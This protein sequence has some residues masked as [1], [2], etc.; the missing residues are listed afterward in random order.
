MESL[1][2]Q[3]LIAMPNLK[4]PYF[5]R[6]V[7]YVCEHNEE[8]AMGLVINIPVDLSLEALLSQID[9]EDAPETIHSLAG[10]PVFQGGPVAQERGFVLHSPKPGY[11]S[12]LSLSDELMV[13]TSTDVLA[14][15]GTHNEPEHYLVTLGYAGWSAGQLEEELASNSW[16]NLPADPA[17]IFDVPSKERWET[18][19]KKIG[20]DIW[21]ISDQVGHA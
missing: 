14:A 20:I 16:L 9:L 4:D 11:S 21:Q 12:S 7:I 19:A 1:Q 2:N 17:I 15:L 6:A 3:F 13:T 8:G 10:H 18:A 5:H